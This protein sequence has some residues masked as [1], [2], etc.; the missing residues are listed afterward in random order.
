[1][2]QEAKSYCAMACRSEI[3][4]MKDKRDNIQLNIRSTSDDG[5]GGDGGREG[6]IA[7][8]EVVVIASII[9]LREGEA[10]GPWLQFSARDLWRK[11]GR[12]WF[13]GLARFVTVNTAHALTCPY[14][15][16]HG[17]AGRMNETKRR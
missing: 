2:A 4:E 13:V 11:R 7:A 14:L 17:G 3:G 5:G 12:R 10:R 6:V 1:L 16:G 15:S 9:A 8:G